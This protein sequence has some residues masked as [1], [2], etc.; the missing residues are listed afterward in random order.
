MVFPVFGQQ[1]RGQA[2]RKFGTPRGAERVDETQRE[3]FAEPR[4]KLSAEGAKDPVLPYM[5]V[6]IRVTLTNITSDTIEVR[7]GA[8]LVKVEVAHAD[9]VFSW[10]PFRPHSGFVGVVKRKLAPNASV[11]TAFEIYSARGATAVEL[12]GSYQVHLS[13]S[14]GRDRCQTRMGFSVIEATGNEADCLAELRKAN[15]LWFLALEGRDVI[16]NDVGWNQQLSWSSALKGLSGIAERHPQSKYAPYCTATAILALAWEHSG[17][18][19]TP[20]PGVDDELRDRIRSLLE[21]RCQAFSHPRELY[22]YGQF[23]RWTAEDRAREFAEKALSRP[24]VDLVIKDRAQVLV[25]DLHK[26]N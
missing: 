16:N 18:E 8:D 20:R 11:T 23:L 24:N 21:H 1:S 10:S 25:D 3:P 19:R 26:P 12:P 13:F 22:A 6:P 9:R 2:I 7:F 14:Q 15:L 4:F 5:P 17:V